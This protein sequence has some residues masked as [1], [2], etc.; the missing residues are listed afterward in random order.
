MASPGVLCAVGAYVLA[1][2]VSCTLNIE[3]TELDSTH[4]GATGMWGESISGVQR[5]TV[6]VDGDW[7]NAD[8]VEVM[9]IFN[10]APGQACTPY[11]ITVSL[12]DCTGAQ[13]TVTGHAM[14]RNVKVGATVKDKISMSCSFV[15]TG[16][17]T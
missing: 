1:E 12:A 11:D 7:T 6:D 16:D 9:T 5:W 13:H 2:P 17:L 14:I 15:G 4:L 8:L 10:T 3:A